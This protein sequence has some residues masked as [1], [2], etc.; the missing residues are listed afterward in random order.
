E[1]PV[2]IP[3]NVL[4]DGYMGEVLE[5]AIA[6]K[7]EPPHLQIE[8][9]PLDDQE[10]EVAIAGRVVGAAHAT[11]KTYALIP[12]WSEEY[13]EN[14]EPLLATLSDG[15][16]AFRLRDL[17]RGRYRLAARA[18]GCAPAWIDV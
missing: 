15:D 1:E 17:P 4:A 7:E 12:H 13:L 16:G 8:L 9:T 6:A 5:V 11:I 3:L 10:R 2:R 14:R 18:S